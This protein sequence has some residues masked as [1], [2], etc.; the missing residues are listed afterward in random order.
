MIDNKR[1]KDAP[2]PEDVKNYLTKA[3]SVELTHIERFGWTLNYV[4]R[5]LFQERV[6]VVMNP[7]GGSIAVLEEDGS[8]NLESNIDT[9]E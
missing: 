3:Q 1:D 2:V 7:G 8:L 5:P 6:V 4:R 9:R